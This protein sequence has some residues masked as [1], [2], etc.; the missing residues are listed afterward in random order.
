VTRLFNVMSFTALAGSC[1]RVKLFCRREIVSY[2]NKWF[3]TLS[4][5]AV[6]SWRFEG[7]FPLRHQLLMLWCLRSSVTPQHQGCWNFKHGTF[8]I[9][10]LSK[11]ILNYDFLKEWVV[12][13]G[14]YLRCVIVLFQNACQDC[15]WQITRTHWPFHTGRATWL[16]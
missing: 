7:T 2:F 4:E 9:L 16:L 10:I 1:P 14:P 5:R 3:V 8:F 15:I 13:K 11:S 12:P 6:V